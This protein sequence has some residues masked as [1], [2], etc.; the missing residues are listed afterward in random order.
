MTTATVMADEVTCISS[1]SELHSADLSVS[2]STNDEALPD[3]SNVESLSE[4][5]HAGVK[6]NS[7]PADTGIS[8][9]PA[10][11][12]NAA[13]QPVDSVTDSTLKESVVQESIMCTLHRFVLPLL[14]VILSG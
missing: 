7:D 13:A 6:S 10:S 8:T 1:T 5:G 2:K 4:K 14:S 3:S 9:V 12:L 11:E